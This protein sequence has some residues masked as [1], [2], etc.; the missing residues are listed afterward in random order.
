[1]SSTPKPFVTHDDNSWATWTD[2]DPCS[3]RT[4]ISSF[5]VTRLRISSVAA[6]SLR[7][8]RPKFCES[9]LAYGG[10]YDG[11]KRPLA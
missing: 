11:R 6:N 9:P 10:A 2:A 1:M 4:V 3:G 5:G 8:H 7:I